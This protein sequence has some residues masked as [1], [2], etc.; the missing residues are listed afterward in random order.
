MSEEEQGSTNLLKAFAF[1][2]FYRII[3]I[4]R[5][6]PFRLVRLLRHFLPKKVPKWSLWVPVNWFIELLFYAI[7]LLGVAE[8]YEL[9]SNLIKFNSRPLTKNEIKL[10]REYFG[11]DLPYYRI[12][13]D[14][15][16]FFGPKFS[17]MAYVGFNTINTWGPIDEQTLLHELIHVW[18]Y[19]HLGAVYIPRAIQAQF[20]DEGYDYGGIPNLILAIRSGKGLKYFNLEQ[21]GDIISDHY[22][23]TRGLKPRWTNA[24]ANELW[25]FEHLLKNLNPKVKS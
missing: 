12:R 13:I 22:C 14:E 11:T 19:K 21:Q 16:A 1:G 8:I 20:S 25:I 7:D 5:L 6:F 2:V 15:Y 10:A 3:D 24:S 4:F 23:L 17:K 18:Q 9:L